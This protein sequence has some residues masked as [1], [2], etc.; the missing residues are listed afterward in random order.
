MPLL[1]D[2]SES[3]IFIPR[4]PAASRRLISNEPV[5]AQSFR[6]KF[7]EKVKFG[8]TSSK[9]EKDISISNKQETTSSIKIQPSSKSSSN[10]E[11]N[12][13]TPPKIDVLNKNLHVSTPL[14]QVDHKLKNIKNSNDKLIK[15]QSDVFNKDLRNQETLNK[16]EY[17]TQTLKVNEK[18][19]IETKNLENTEKE[20]IEVIDVKLPIIIEKEPKLEIYEVEKESDNFKLPVINKNEPSIELNDKNIKRDKDKINNNNNNRNRKINKQKDNFKLP[21]IAEAEIDDT[22]NHN[23]KNN[24]RK[25]LQ[26]IQER[27]PVQKKVIENVKKDNEPDRESNS[28]QKDLN[29]PNNKE[30]DKNSIDLEET[31]T[32][33]VVFKH[34]VIVSSQDLNIGSLKGNQLNNKGKT[35]KVK[36]K[37]KNKHSKTE[38][39]IEI[40]LETDQNDENKENLSTDKKQ[41]NKKKRNKKGRKKKNRNKEV[42][43]RLNNAVSRRVTVEKKKVEEDEFCILSKECMNTKICSLDSNCMRCKMGS[44]I[45][46][47]TKRSLPEPSLR[48]PRKRKR[49]DDSSVKKRKDEESQKKKKGDENSAKRR[50]EGERPKKRKNEEEHPVFSE[51]AFEVNR[52][53]TKPKGNKQKG[54]KGKN[55]KGKHKQK[56]A[57]RLIRQALKKANPSKISKL[58]GCCLCCCET[59]T[60]STG[61]NFFGTRSD[62]GSEGF[63]KIL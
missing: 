46:A 27:S 60:R 47:R 15:D 32:G 13:E 2:I 12:I 44:R 7:E 16:Q 62:N 18:K 51:P 61:W 20:K 14:L 8:A 36:K 33:E 29:R 3:E 28:E 53:K 4:N 56:S 35:D 19:K 39:N 34:P 31:K 45:L 17:N 41:K 26:N 37:N 63:G 21:V 5:E 43:T 42:H 48:E 9:L 50:K 22:K 49:M 24:N 6:D 54:N 10:K 59:D 57:I 58:G 55:K 11:K 38:D 1:S 30:N 23:K 52:N 40:I 25:N